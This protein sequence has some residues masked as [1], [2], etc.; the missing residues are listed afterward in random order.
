MNAIVE[1]WIMTFST[2]ISVRTAC[3][4]YYEFKAKTMATNKLAT[5]TG[6]NANRKDR[7]KSIQHDSIRKRS[8]QQ[9]RETITKLLQ[10]CSIENQKQM[11]RE[12]TEKSSQRNRQKAY[13]CKDII[14]CEIS[15]SHGGEYD[16]QS[17]LLGCTAV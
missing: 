13:T 5:S 7:V 3:F 17:C 15:S 12:G 8:H 10:K 9:L 2:D 4:R 6:I 1:M 11:Q 14:F 16:V